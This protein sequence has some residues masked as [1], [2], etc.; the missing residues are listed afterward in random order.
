MAVLSNVK[1]H[2]DTGDYFKELPFYNKPMEKPE[3]KRLK[4]IDRL[5]ELPFY[6]QLSVIKTNQVFRGYAMS[7]KVEIIE[8]KDPIVQLEASKSS[9]KDMFS[10]LLNEI[11]DFK[12]QI[13]VKI[14]LKNHKHNGGIEIVPVYFNSLT[15]T[16]VNHRFILEKKFCT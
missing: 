7:Q 1:S 10:D 12:Y 6:E 11:R 13:T 5:A 16:V 3:V 15:K 4:N 2:S 8:R 9:I 14:Q